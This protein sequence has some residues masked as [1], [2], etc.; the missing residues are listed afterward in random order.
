MTPATVFIPAPVRSPRDGP[1]R[2]VAE[3]PSCPD[4]SRRRV[5]KRFEALP[6]NRWELRLAKP[7]SELPKGKLAVSVKDMQGNV[8]RVERT[9]SL[10]PPK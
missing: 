9:F 1:I 5:A 8:T 3:V 10:A 6:D 2:R 7:I 4:R